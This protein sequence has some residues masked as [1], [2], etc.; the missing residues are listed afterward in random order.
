MSE[1]SPSTSILKGFCNAGEAVLLAWLL[2]RWFGRPFTFCDLRRVGGFFTAVVIAVSISAIGGA[3]TMTTLQAAAPFWDVWRTWFLSDAV[4]ILVIAPLLIELGQLRSQ[5]RSRAELIEGTGTVVLIALA[6]IYAVT[7]PTGTWLSFEPDAIAFLVLLW[8]TARNQE[9]F[10]IA[11]AFAVSIAVI[12]AATYGTGHFGDVTL[13]IAQRVQ[14]A[15]VVAIMV[16]AFTLVLSALFTER[17][18]S[19]AELKQSNNRLQLALDCA[20]LG[21]WS[22]QLS[23]GRFENDVRDRRI[24]GHGQEPPP[25]SLAEMRCQVHPDD[26]SKLDATFREL[27][28]AGGSS[29][30][31]YRLA[32]RTDREDAGRERWVTLEGTVVRRADG[33]PEQFL[34]VTRDITE[35]KHAENTLRTSEERLRRVSDNA[36]VGL[37]RCSRDWFYLSANPAYAKIAG[38]PLDQIVGWPMAEVIGA[39]AVATIRPY[40]ERVLRGEHVIYEAEVPY[41]G[42]GTRYMHV[43]YTPD[44]DA[45][46]QIVGW[47]ASVTDITERKHAENALRQREVELGEAQRL[48]HIGSWFWEAETD[49]LV[50]SDELLRIYGLDPATQRVL[51]LGDQRDRWHPVDDWERLKAAIQRTMQ[52]GLGYELEL[53]AFRNEVPIW[54]TARG[55]AVR[56]SKG[57]IVGLRGTVQDITERKQAE[58]ALAD[59]NLQLRLA[60]MAG[61][62]GSYAYDTFT[63]IGQISS[64]YAAI[65]GLTEGTTEITRSEWLARVHP[66]D[67]ERVQLC[68]SEALRERRAEYKVDYRI[69][70]HD[71]E[72]RWIESR[73]FIMYGSDATGHRLTGVNIDVTDRKRAEQALVERNILLALAGRAARVGTFAYDT[74]TEIMQISADYAAIHDFPEGTTEIARGECLA[75]VHPEDVERVRL[76]RSEAFRERWSEYSAE[77][78][79]I[80]PGGEIRWVEIRCFI[81]YAGNGHPKRVVGVSTDVTDR[82]Q[83][84]LWLAERNSQLDLAGQIAR[85]G[86]FTYDHATQKLQIS[87]GFATIYGMPENV[88]EIS[89]KGW[90]MMVHPDDLPRLDT[91]AR[92]ALTRREKEL[93]LEFRILRH[94]EVRWIESRML[95]SY[96]DTGKPTRRIGAQIDVTE[97]RRAE[98]HKGLLVAELD[99]RVKNTLATV[100]AVVSQTRQGRRS[101]ADFAAALEGR[102]RSMAA[103]HELLS[104]RRWS[105]VSL[106]NVVSHELEPY[107][108]RNNTE[109]NGPYVALRPEAGQAMAMVI[110]ELATNAAKYGALSTKKGRVSIQWDR[111]LN[112]RP[113]SDLVLE[114]QEI[115]GPPVSAPRNSG[116]GT[117]TIR[118]LIPYEFHGTVDLVFAPEGVRC[119][120][121]LPGDWLS[122]AVDPYDPGSGVIAGAAAK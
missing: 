38:K 69:V 107:A 19:E 100:S 60:E 41:A 109:I 102:L 113:R 11:G 9:P 121:K 91:V 13:P 21:T 5:R 6:S 117:S 51:T 112:G 96:D 83:A 30:A 98:D 40:V 93:V 35:R 80:R 36:D 97:R 82:K 8:L 76:A 37:I 46:G 28:H 10:A 58:L 29:R 55:A 23:T 31:E 39:E 42:A 48:A 65:H 104:A 24:H 3:A 111:R 7:F 92:G 120:L 103:T 53:R 17:R 62:I 20:E 79:I 85:I 110:H 74:D 89:R 54:I 66:E 87:P 75:T 50:A 59:R 118:D 15:Q 64:G 122:D 114:W 63:E 18:R 47:V 105:G 57:Q 16:T 108:S 27:R 52:T 26:L 84:E 88:L 106:A 86:T 45:A 90:R 81:T 2:N 95:I 67:V 12:G 61:L 72:V 49:A 70:R 119:R 116:F 56:N 68:R 43:S 14:G 33:R 71:G 73:V 32:P 94:G 115:G 4:G 77:Y 44:T 1:R 34:G 78:R 101:V 25:K 99:H 22:L